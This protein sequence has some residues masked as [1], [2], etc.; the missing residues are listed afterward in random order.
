MRF[1]DT[2][3]ALLLRLAALIGLA[4]CG[5]MSAE[6]T[7]P[8]DASGADAGPIYVGGATPPATLGMGGPLPH[9]QG[10]EGGAITDAGATDGRARW[11]RDATRCARI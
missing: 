8:S 11:V 7:L 5:G 3:V 9:A 4:G 10:D 2:R 6:S 1:L